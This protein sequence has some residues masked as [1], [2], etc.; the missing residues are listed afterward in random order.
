MLAHPIVVICM[1]LDTT[2]YVIENSLRCRCNRP[3]IFD[4]PMRDMGTQLVRDIAT[5]D[6]SEQQY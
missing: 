6:H 1:A 2:E 4:H 3:R 5:P